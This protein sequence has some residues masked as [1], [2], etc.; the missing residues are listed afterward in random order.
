MSLFRVSALGALALILLALQPQQAAAQKLPGGSWQQSC[1]D[2]RM[3]GDVLRAECRTVDGRWNRTGID[4]DRCGRG[5]TVANRN[6]DLVC[7]SM[8]N[9]GNQNSPPG[10]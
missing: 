4:L 2:A 3:D 8:G 5:G 10:S 1:R 6:G 7:E 9:V